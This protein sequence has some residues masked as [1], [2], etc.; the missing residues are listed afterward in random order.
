MF[1]AMLLYMYAIVYLIGPTILLSYTKRYYYGESVYRGWASGAHTHTY[2]CTDRDTSYNMRPCIVYYTKHIQNIPASCSYK[3]VQHTLV[4]LRWCCVYRKTMA[5]YYYYYQYALRIRVCV[6]AY[7][8][9]CMYT[10][11]PSFYWMYTST[12]EWYQ[13][14]MICTW[15]H[16]CTWM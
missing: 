7:V 12:V 1:M 10:K 8:H 3:Q 13:N 15:S 2:T 14:I 9:V 4:R 5:T 16:A 6:C 11:F